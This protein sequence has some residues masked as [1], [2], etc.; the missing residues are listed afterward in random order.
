PEIAGVTLAA[1]YVSAPGPGV[2]G[3][4][5]YAVVPPGGRRVGLAIGDV[6]GHGVACLAAM[7]EARFA[8][9]ALAR[10]Q[11]E[12]AEVLRELNE[13]LLVYGA[14]PLITAVYGVLD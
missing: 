9:R 2:I 14:E 7:A 12:P 11:V 6:A 1:R 4:D 5:W 10:D 3:G 8:L 13:H